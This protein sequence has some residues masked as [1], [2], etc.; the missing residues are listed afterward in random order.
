M[1]NHFLLKRS[2]F[3]DLLFI[4]L[5]IVYLL[6]IWIF[7]FTPSTDGPSHLDNANILLNI[8]HPNCHLSNEYFELN[9]RIVPNIFIY[10]VLSLL[11]FIFPYLIALKVMASIYIIL[12]PLSLRYTINSINNSASI[13]SYL[14]FPFVVNYFYHMG[15]FNYL[16]SVVIYLFILGYW[17][18]NY[19][20]LNF[21]KI[22]TLSYLLILLYFT[23]IFSIVL[24]I[25]TIPILLI[26]FFSMN[27]GGKE[28]QV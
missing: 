8:I 15:F 21:A 4:L 3:D 20:Q 13:V 14:S 26:W 9:K 10:P 17:I 22:I 6:P 19:Y 2:P 16:F 12:F 23:H 27:R 24:I 1:I 18:R 28:N 11:L 5:I 25:I 7:H